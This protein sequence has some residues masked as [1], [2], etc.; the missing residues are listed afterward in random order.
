MTRKPKKTNTKKKKI[1]APSGRVR[2]LHAS[3]EEDLES[4][5][6]PGTETESRWNRPRRQRICLRIDTEVVD[7][8]KAK[9]AGYQTRINRV[10]RKVMEEG[11]KRA[12]R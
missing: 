1:R 4:V 7:W 11:K 3:L 9:G 5:M 2:Q 12:G 10:L 8:F 6:E